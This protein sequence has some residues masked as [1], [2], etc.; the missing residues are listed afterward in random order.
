MYL[1]ILQEVCSNE[2]ANIS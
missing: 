1:P 2:W